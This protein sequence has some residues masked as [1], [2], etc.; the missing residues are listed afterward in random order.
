MLREEVLRVYDPVL[1]IIA[2]F[3]LKRIHN[4]RESPAFVMASEVLYILKKKGFRASCLKNSRNIK[5]Q[6]SLGITG[7][8]MTSAECILLDT[9]YGK[10]LAGKTCQ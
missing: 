2:K 9:S 5:E 1:D 7:K 6:C 3:V 8:A 10:G 4:H